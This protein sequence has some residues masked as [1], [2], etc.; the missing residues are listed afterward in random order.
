MDWI[1][2]KLENTGKKIRNLPL[3]YALLVYLLSGFLAAA[4]LS[5]VSVSFAAHWCMLSLRDMGI[6]IYEFHISGIWI[7][8]MG[9]SRRSRMSP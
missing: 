2:E 3:K 6:E 7:N 1:N 5:A 8:T 4:A 9:E